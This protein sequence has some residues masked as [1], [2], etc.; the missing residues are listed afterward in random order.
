MLLV[1]LLLVESWLLSSNAIGFWSEPLVES[2]S[3]ALPEMPVGPSPAAPH[4]ESEAIDN[5]LKAFEV[6]ETRRERIVPAI[7]HSSRKHDLDAR[8]VASVIIVESR[9][10][11]FAISPSDAVGVMQIHVPTWASVVDNEGINLF[12]VEDNVDF[13]VRILKSYVARHGRDQGV[14][15][16]I[17]WRSGDPESIQNA[18][19][20]LRKVQG[21]YSSTAG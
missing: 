12:K 11:P 2:S 5:L 17:G 10:N 8:L 7:M 21:V 1:S 18:E 6:G 16:Y 20:Y 3:V 9:G 15:R 19:G 4:D 14:M 13:G